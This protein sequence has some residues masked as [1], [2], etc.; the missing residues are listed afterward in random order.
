MIKRFMKIAAVVSPVLLSPLLFAQNSPDVQQTY[1]MRCSGCHGDD[2]QGT[3]QGPALA[4]SLSVRARSAQSLRG[5]I[6]TGVPAAGMPAFDL[7]ADTIDALATMI[8]SWN[9]VAAKA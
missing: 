4:G 2:G 7:P 1:S 5:V 6:R 3:G 8:A 9:A